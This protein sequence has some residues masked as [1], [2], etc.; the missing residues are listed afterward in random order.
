MNQSSPF[1]QLTNVNGASS[2]QPTYQPG[3][4]DILKTAPTNEAALLTHALPT[5]T[6]QYQHQVSNYLGNVNGL[7]ADNMVNPQVY[8]AQYHLQADP[9]LAQYHT[10]TNNLNDELA[11]KN[12]TGGSYDALAHGI[13]N[14]NLGLN[15][16]QAANYAVGT[17]LDATGKYLGWQG[18][19]ATTAG[20]EVASLGNLG[21]TYQN[22]SSGLQ[23]QL[24][25]PFQ[26]YSQYQDVVNPLQ[27]ARAQ[28]IYQTPTGFQN[29][30]G[31]IGAFSDS[32]VPG[33]G[34]AYT[35]LGNTFGNPGANSQYQTHGSILG[36]VTSALG[37]LGKGGAGLI[38]A[39]SAP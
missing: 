13:L 3:Q 19:G 7:T 28:M 9:Q 33:T 4:K 35:S 16:G 23:S 22:L 2:Y 27:E 17:G 34:G 31:Q 32:I 5:A 39:G 24:M 8:N 26:Q 15:L 29:T 1:G 25:N 6:D 14:K 18:D 12:L 11:A 10:D 21:T 36:S 20:N 38:A 37:A 30:M